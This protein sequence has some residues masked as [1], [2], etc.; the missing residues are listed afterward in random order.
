MVLVGVGPP[1]GEFLRRF[2]AVSKKVPRVVRRVNQPH[3]V[4]VV[5]LKYTPNVFLI[6]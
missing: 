5:N 3:T 4:T 1:P 2:T 6:L